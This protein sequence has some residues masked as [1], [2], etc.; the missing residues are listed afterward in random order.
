MPVIT[1]PQQNDF[2][3]SSISESSYIGLRRIDVKN[4]PGKAMSRNNK[5]RMLIF[6][7]TDGQ[8]VKTPIMSSDMSMVPPNMLP[9]GGYVNWAMWEPNLAGKHEKCVEILKGQTQTQY[10]Y[11]RR[12]GQWNDIPC[13]KKRSK[14]CLLTF[15]PTGGLDSI[16]KS[17]N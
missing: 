9:P 10:G 2:I 3:K 4:F 17:L 8:F 6:M 13:D 7:W 12:D 5:P 14:L 1:N 11:R 15:T 16:L